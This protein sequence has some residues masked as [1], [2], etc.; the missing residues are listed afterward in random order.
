MYTLKLLVRKQ[1]LFAHLDS[2]YS[3]IYGTHTH[4]PTADER[5]SANGTG[6]ITDIGITGAY[7]SVIGMTKSSVLSTFLD[8]DKKTST[9]RK[10]FEVAKEEPWLSFLI[11]DFDITSGKCISLSREQWRHQDL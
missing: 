6:Y 3:L 9:K 4:V 8:A 1:A 7:N 10:K 11:A 2:K 5:I